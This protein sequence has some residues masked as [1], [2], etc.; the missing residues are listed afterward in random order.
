[1]ATARRYFAEAAG[2]AHANHFAGPRRMALSGL[3]LAYATLGDASAAAEVLAERAAVPEFG[4]L[5]P[6]Q[7]LADAWTAIASRQPREAAELLS[8]AAGHAA[9][10]AHHVTESWL[11]H[12]LMRVGGLD[13]SARLLELADI[14]DSPLVSARARH[15]AA[16]RAR[17]PAELNGAA[18]EFEAVG[19]MLLAAE[20]AVGAA[21]AF[22]RAGEKRAETAALRRSEALASACE[23]AT[24]PALFHAT[25]HEPLSRREREIA[26]LAA[27]GMASKD[28]AERLY[29]SVRTV[30]NHLQRVYTKLGVSGRAD[31]A[32]ALGSSS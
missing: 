14:C 7:R 20:A 24:T 8:D 6:E 29:L 15:A 23:G 12:D 25:A 4:F 32:K 10:T 28:I 18:D 16:V 17:N 19:A 11:L 2:L 1:M 9:S 22:G 3:A 30:D 31:L 13:T 21:E 5:G 26:M 27:E